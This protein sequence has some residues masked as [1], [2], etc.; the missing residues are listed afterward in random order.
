[1]VDTNGVVKFKIQESVTRSWTSDV[2]DLSAVQSA[3]LTDS[4]FNTDI[5]VWDETLGEYRIDSDVIFNSDDTFTYQKSTIEYFY[6]EGSGKLEGQLGTVQ[7]RSLE[8]PVND[9]DFPTVTDSFIRQEFVQF[10]DSD[11]VSQLQ[12][13]KVR[14]QIWNQQ[15]IESAPGKLLA[16]GDAGPDRL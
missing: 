7:A 1:M 13:A 4:I 15:S 9:G 2:L 6:A 8:Q 11:G 16:D 12:V 10:T 5:V 3:L 14:N